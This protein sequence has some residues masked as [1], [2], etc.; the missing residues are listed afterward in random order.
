MQMKLTVSHGSFKASL[1]PKDTNKGLLRWILKIAIMI[2]HS[3]FINLTSRQF[4]IIKVRAISM[5]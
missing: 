2:Y 1:A 3:C 5:L 4:N